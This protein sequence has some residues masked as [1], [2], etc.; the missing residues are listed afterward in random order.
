MNKDVTPR[1]AGLMPFIRMKKNENFIGKT[2]LAE[3]LK[4]PMSRQVVMLEVDTDE[5]DPEGDESVLV[6]GKPVGYTTSGCFSPK[7]NKGKT[8]KTG[9][10]TGYSKHFYTEKVM[11][12]LPAKLD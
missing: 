6:C 7:I 3:E 1:E 8:R 11:L 2:A 10:F 4:H 5:V 12:L 9:N